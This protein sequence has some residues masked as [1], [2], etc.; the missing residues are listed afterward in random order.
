MMPLNMGLI[1]KGAPESALFSVMS[2]CLEA[3]AKANG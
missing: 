3:K 2:T 1:K